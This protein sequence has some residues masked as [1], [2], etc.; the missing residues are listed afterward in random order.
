[1]PQQGNTTLVIGAVMIASYQL[2]FK[3]ISKGKI[4][5]KT[6]VGQVSKLNKRSLGPMTINHPEDKDEL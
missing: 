6:D 5:F 4:T 3:K 2:N 1:M